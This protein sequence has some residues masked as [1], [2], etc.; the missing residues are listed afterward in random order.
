M[1]TI[2]DILKKRLPAVE[3]TDEA[4]CKVTVLK[5]DNLI[6]GVRIDNSLEITLADEGTVNRLFGIDIE[7]LLNE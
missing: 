6:Y 7:D 4:I 2:T 3:F 5:F 1:S